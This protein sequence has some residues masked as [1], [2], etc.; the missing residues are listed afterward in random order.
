[1]LTPVLLL[2]SNF[3]PAS[4]SSIILRFDQALSVVVLLIEQRCIQEATYFK[5]GK[6][7]VVVVHIENS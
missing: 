7:S 4:S 1:M 2:E 5:T 3:V 6:T